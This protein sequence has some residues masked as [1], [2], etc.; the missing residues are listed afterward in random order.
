M[1]SSTHRGEQFD[2]LHAR[3]GATDAE[4]QQVKHDM[5]MQ[6]KIRDLADFSKKKQDERKI[7]I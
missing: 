1:K 6:K 2:I 7:A 5:I 4:I 3:N